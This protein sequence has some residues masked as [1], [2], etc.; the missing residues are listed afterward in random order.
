ML[1]LIDNFL[2]KITMYRLV[3][4]YLIFL[5][6]GAALFGLFGL[7]PYT[8]LGIALSSL[9][10]T[11][12]CWL[13]NKLFAWGFAAQTNVESVYITAL[14][15]ALIIAPQTTASGYMFLFWAAVLA[16]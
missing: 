7:L 5:L 2:N 11:A 1:Q 9:F 8:F 12:V 16:M 15:L 14:I 13:V 10:V 4:Y 6:V 3:L